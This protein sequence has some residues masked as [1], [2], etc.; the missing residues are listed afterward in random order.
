MYI[1]IYIYTHVCVYA[2]TYLYITHLLVRW[3][4]A[5]RTA[6]ATE[7]VALA[8]VAAGGLLCGRR[9]WYFT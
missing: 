4:P 5:V 7:R 6:G 1:Y 3:G 8:A 2:S 9:H